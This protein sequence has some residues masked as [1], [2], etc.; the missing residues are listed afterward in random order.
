MKLNEDEVS[1]KFAELWKNSPIRI[2]LAVCQT[3]VQ[4]AAALD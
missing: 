2:K 3:G 4:T 1:Q